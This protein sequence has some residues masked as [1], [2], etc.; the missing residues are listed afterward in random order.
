MIAHFLE[1]SGYRKAQ[2][3]MVQATCRLHAVM[4]ELGVRDPGIE[5]VE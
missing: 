4:Q 3:A 2:A 5:L 1:L